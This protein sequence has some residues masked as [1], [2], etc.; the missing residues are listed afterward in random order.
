MWIDLAPN[1]IS[2]AIFFIIGI[3]LAATP[4]LWGYVKRRRSW[5][6]PDFDAPIRKEDYFNTVTSSREIPGVPGAPT[7]ESDSLVI[8]DIQP[9]L[10]VATSRNFKTFHY[11]AE[12][13]EHRFNFG[14]AGRS[15]NIILF[16]GGARN[17][18]T[19]ASLDAL[20]SPLKFIDYSIIDLQNVG[21]VYVPVR[22]PS[23]GNRV[24]TDFAL[25]VK[26]QNPF[27]RDRRLYVFAGI[28]KPGTRGAAK[29]VNPPYAGIIENATKGLSGFVALI[30]NEVTYFGNQPRSPYM[31]SPKSVI[32]VYPL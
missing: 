22:D 13:Y 19:E 16:G 29:C 11:T 25:I 6:T 1:L 7:S 9:L 23:I 3:L 21:D 26:A 27:G 31:V 15:N 28:H 20:H 2:E 18:V 30:E 10:I 32:K 12:G 8:G 4:W 17:S 24:I 14:S 5:F